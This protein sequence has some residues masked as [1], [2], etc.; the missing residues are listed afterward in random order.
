MMGYTAVLDLTHGGATLARWLTAMG[1]RVVGMDVYHTLSSHEKEELED[2]GIALVEQLPEGCTLVVAPVHLPPIPATRRAEKLGIEMITH[3]EAV[4]RLA[5]E[6]FPELCNTCVEITGT[7]G[8]TTASVLLARLL[9]CDGRTVCH[10]SMGTDVLE[11]CAQVKH[12]KA[13]STTP[14]S[15]LNVLERAKKLD[16]KHIVLEVSLGVCGLGRAVLT[17][18]EEEYPIAGG[19]LSSTHAKT[20]IL[21]HP[22]KGF[23]MAVPDEGI[24][25][26][27]H[28]AHYLSDGQEVRLTSG[29]GK[30]VAISLDGAKGELKGMFDPPMYKQA[31]VRAVAGGVL[32]GIPVHTIEHHLSHIPLSVK[33]RMSVSMAGDVQLVDCSGSGLKA[34]AVERAVRVAIARFGRV[35]VL[36]VGEG[37]T[38]CEGLDSSML[39]QLLSQHSKEV[40]E[41]IRMGG[42]ASYEQG[43]EYALSLVSSGVVLLCIKCFR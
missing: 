29:D 3:H 9:S 15:I 20:M 33:G 24:P 16:S 35:D 28:T 23:V 13:Y 31:L 17:T 4:R 42:C 40:G 25:T 39:E 38:V 43:L 12:W 19:A 6:C 10:T 2:M 8:K 22:P 1:E 41:V 37:R 21:S 26:C 18:L 11:G 27:P 30:Q 7:R 34:E 5:C 32:G 14:A 36:V